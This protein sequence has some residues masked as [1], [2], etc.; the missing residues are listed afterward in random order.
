MVVGSPRGGFRRCEESWGRERKTEREGEEERAPGSCEGRHQKGADSDMRAGRRSRGSP[1]RRAVFGSG[2]GSKGVL[3]WAWAKPDEG[4]PLQCGLVCPGLLE[5]GR[6]RCAA[7]RRRYSR[8]A[9]APNI[10]RAGAGGRS[11][12]VGMSRR[13]ALVWPPEVVMAVSKED[14][15][16]PGPCHGSCSRCNGWGM[17]RGN[18]DTIAINKN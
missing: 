2:A 6:S 17:S 12:P 14:V 8:S 4:P 15:T 7:L 9:R 3:A 10:L 13:G 11:L 16:I 18:N 1:T 5:G